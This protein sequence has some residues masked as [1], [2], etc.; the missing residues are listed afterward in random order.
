MS[1]KKKP[2]IVVIGSGIG[3]MAS[4]ALFAKS[5]YEV[6]VLE[7]HGSLIGGHGRCLTFQ[8]LSFSMGPQYVWHF[9]Q[10]DV[11][12]RFLNYLE[13]DRD[14]RFLDLE[15]DGFERIFV[16]KKYQPDFCDFRVPLGLDSFRKSMVMRFPEH[17]KNLNCFF[18]DMHDIYDAYVSLYGDPTQDESW[19]RYA[20]DFLFSS[21][22]KIS[23]KVKFLGNLFSSVKDFF[24]KYHLP[25]VCRRILYG[26]GGIFAENESHMSAVGYVVA[27][28]N[29]HQG[30]RYPEKGF[31]TFFSALKDV[32][33]RHGG[34]VENGKRAAGIDVTGESAKRVLCSDG[35]LYDCDMVFS[36]IS[37]RLTC[38][39]LPEKYRVDFSYNPSHSV[40]T[41]CIGLKKRIPSLRDEMRGRNFWWQDGHEVDYDTTD[42]TRLPGMLFI[43]SPTANG[44]GDL[45]G[46]DDRDSLVVF[47]PGNYDQEKGIYDLGPDAVAAWKKDLAHMVID[48]IDANVIPGVK[49]NLL[50]AEVISSVD[51][52]HDT[53]GE[54]GNA[55]GTRLTVKEILTTA[56]PCE[57]PVSNLYNVSASY[58]APGIASGVKTGVRLLYRLAQVKI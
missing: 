6:H 37:P 53:L 44:F 21:E 4:A 9:K 51:I 24:D 26:H 32:I 28:A 7:Q 20:A 50:F 42:V 30:A 14:I 57:Y 22:M 11:G 23:N 49:D 1:K 17:A 38:N 10:G 5:G 47:C 43:N 40:P 2:V 13:L 45:S 54:K 16:G 8:D 29:Y 25:E 18:D 31:Y 39:L 41:I 15:H 3:G 56:V 55:Y 12:D 58:N 46:N 19:F 27:T 35:S 48:I 34:T 33:E 36:D 52:E